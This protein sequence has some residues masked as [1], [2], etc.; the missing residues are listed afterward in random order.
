MTDSTRFIHH[1]R[2]HTSP[3]RTTGHAVVRRLVLLSLL[4]LLSLAVVGAQP[5]GLRILPTAGT[6]T[7]IEQYG[8]TWYFDSEVEYG[9]FV[10]G[11][12][13]VVG[14]VTVTDVDPAPRRNSNGRYVH[15]SQINPTGQQARDSSGSQ[16]NE[17][18]RVSFP[19][20]LDPSS[21]PISLVSSVSRNPDGSVSSGSPVGE[22]AVLTVL[23]MIPASGTFRP[24]MIGDYKPLFNWSDVESNWMRLDAN[25]L[26]LPSGQSAPDSFGFANNLERPWTLHGGSWSAEQ[27]YPMS[28]MPDYHG[29]ISQLLANAATSMLVRD[30]DWNDPGERERLVRNYIQV[31]IEY[32][33]MQT[34]NAGT[35][36]ANYWL[37]STFAGLMLGEDNMLNLFAD[38]LNKTE[39]H[40]PILKWY[41]EMDN[42]G[43]GTQTDRPSGR[44][45]E[46]SR[47]GVT[48]GRWIAEGTTYTD[49]PNG[50]RYGV[51]S[52][53]EQDTWTGY[54]ERTGR[55]P[56][57]YDSHW[58]HLS[59]RENNPGAS[60]AYKRMHSRPVTGFGFVALALGIDDK[61]GNDRYMPYVDRWMYETEDGPIYDSY[62][63]N[64]QG[65]W[66]ASSNNAF[67]DA[68]WREYRA[69]FDP[70]PPGS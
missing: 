34:N 39:Y 22:L 17:S 11:D 29:N 44:F 68:M 35:P 8:I 45:P 26:P 27:S 15:G 31:G 46:S 56:V 53:G 54:Y 42:V 6:T 4:F 50:S 23:D 14:P 37:P 5:S 55:R 10:N 3:A 33:G 66:W 67:V 12:Y 13:W 19:V 58:E 25:S 70:S 48:L 51:I 59:P 40:E 64:L 36:R 16:F 52:G 38:G 47:T 18:L 61:I 41:G 65:Y 20:T 7:S 62:G 1:S 32:W 57:F 60:A 21:N 63:E 24:T 28:N 43:R 30:A 9:Q 69:S 2:A 49:D